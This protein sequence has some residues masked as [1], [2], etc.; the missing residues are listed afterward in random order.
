MM[1][2][3]DVFSATS[4]GELRQ[5]FVAE[6]SRIGERV[7]FEF[8]RP[9]MQCV[10]RNVVLCAKFVNELRI[11]IGRLPNV[12]VHMADNGEQ[13]CIVRWFAIANDD[14]GQQERD[15]IGAAAHAEHKW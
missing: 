11:I 2:D 15:G 10:T 9:H 13:R 12:M 7:S 5:R 6:H 14:A 1:C 4:L 3:H 8:C